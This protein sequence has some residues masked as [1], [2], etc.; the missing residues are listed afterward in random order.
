MGLLQYLADELEVGNP[1]SHRTLP[2]SKE[3]QRTFGHNKTAG[4]VVKDAKEKERG[5]SRECVTKSCESTK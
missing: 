4:R 2:K 3:T 1:T 5:N